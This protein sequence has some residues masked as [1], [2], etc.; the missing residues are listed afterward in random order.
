[1]IN[2][3]CAKF[4][5]FDIQSC[6]LIIADPPDNINIKYQNYNDNLPKKEYENLMRIWLEKS[7]NTCKGP[8]FWIFNEKHTRLIENLIYELDI[9]LIQRIYWY[10]LF[11]QNQRKK[12]APC[13]RPIYWLNSPFFLPENIKVPSVRQKMGDKRAK[14]G[15][16]IP[17]NV[18]TFS[19]VCGTFNERRKWHQCQ[20]PE[21]LVERIVL[22][23]SNPDGI[24]FDPFVGSG[25]TARVCQKYNKNC[26]GLDVSGYYLGEIKSEL[27]LDF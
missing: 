20:L 25:T 6:D 11:G 12:Y 15:G 7:K 10:F 5:E 3:F 21:A 19:R 1:M 18:W 24:V 2:L 17:D 27:G 26:I 16:K 9:P 23:H 8:I 4:E 22:G 13:T 14:S